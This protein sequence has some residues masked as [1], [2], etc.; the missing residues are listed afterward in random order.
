MQDSSFHFKEIAERMSETQKSR[1]AFV[2][3]PAVGVLNIPSQTFIVLFL[4]NKSK[5][6]GSFSKL[7]EHCYSHSIAPYCTSEAILLI[8]NVL[9]TF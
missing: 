4:S 1:R 6:H 8:S 2:L 3:N 7:K 5:A 9:V